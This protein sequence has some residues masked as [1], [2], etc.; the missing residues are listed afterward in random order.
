MKIEL[1][2]GRDIQSQ[3]ISAGYATIDDYLLMLLVKTPPVLRSSAVSKTSTLAGCSP[4]KSLTSICTKSVAS[5]RAHELPRDHLS[6]SPRRHP[7][8][9]PLVGNAAIQPSGRELVQQDLS[10]DHRSFDA[11]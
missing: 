7:R 8:D 4:S 3:A 10:G 1:H 11:P 2:T 6:A 5:L 9:H